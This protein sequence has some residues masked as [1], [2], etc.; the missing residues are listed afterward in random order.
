MQVFVC[1]RSSFSRL[2][3]VLATV[4]LGLVACSGS[5]KGDADVAPDTVADAPADVLPEA[6]ADVPGPDDVGFPD[7]DWAS[8]PRLPADKVFTTRYAAG[9]GRADVT[10]DHAVPLGGFGFCAGSAEACRYSEGVHDVLSALAAALADTETGEV[11]IFVAVDSAGMLRPDIDDIHLAAQRALYE[12]H[13]VY[14]EGSRVVVSASHAHSA[15]DSTG[16][17]GPNSNPRDEVYL[18]Y[19]KSQTVAAVVQAFGDLQDARLDW[20]KTTAP[21]S[22]EDTFGSDDE[23]YVLR[24]RTPADAPIVLLTRWPAHP[25]CYGSDNNGLS[26]DYLGAFR[27]KSEELLGGLSVFLQGPIGTVYPDRTSVIPCGSEDLFP[28]GWQD[29]EVGDQ[30]VKA[31]CVGINLANQVA[32]ALQATTPVAETGVVARYTTFEFHPTNLAFMALAKMGQIAIPYVDVKDPTSRMKSALS[33]ITVGD[34]DFLTTPGEAFPSFAAKGADK[35]KAA[36]RATP[37]TLGLAQ[38]WMGYLLTTEGWAEDNDETAYHKGLS[39]SSELEGPY[40]DAV[41]SL[42]DL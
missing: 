29:P 22:D 28:E 35:L 39:P 27:K 16:L 19:L 9:A 40:L 38:D 11:V 8:L 21:N 6:V 18:A 31:T 26:A 5:D 33:W 32:A 34:L 20:A 7:V 37:I 41:Q 42:I 13:G 17:W 10:P 24:A 2:L 12:T 3:V 36:G 15:P 25:T 1:R 23:V 4:G 30:D 14:V